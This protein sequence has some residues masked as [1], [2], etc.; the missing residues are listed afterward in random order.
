MSQDP[1]PIKEIPPDVVQTRFVGKESEILKLIRELE[2]AFGIILYPSKPKP[3][4][5]HAGLF[6]V[7]CEIPFRRSVV[8]KGA[9]LD[10]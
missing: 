3:D 5:Q 10:E 6:R 4:F 1:R 7:Y 2:A 9:R 8:K